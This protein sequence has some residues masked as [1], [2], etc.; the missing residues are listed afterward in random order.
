MPEM[1][2]RV[3][4]PDGRT[5]NCYSPSR[6]IAEHLTASTYYPLPDFLARARLGLNAASDRVRA[7][8]GMGCAQAMAQLRAIET[9]AA[10]HAPQS[11]ILVE[12]ISEL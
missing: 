4:W 2:F 1:I 9:G 11:T 3:V 7:K 12:S 5:E 8:F 6:V 10:R